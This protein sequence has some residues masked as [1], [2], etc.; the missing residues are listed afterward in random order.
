[1]KV[2]PLFAAPPPAPAWALLDRY[3]AAAEDQG[4]PA[5]ICITKLDLAD[6]E[7]LQPELT[8]YEQIGYQILTTSAVSGEGIARLRDALR[9]RVTVFVG[10]S[11]VGKTSLL[12]SIEP[13]LG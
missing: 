6:P 5:I 1:D 8:V 7:E 4:L 10:K 11:G 12:N 2:I 13:G 9:G 3:L